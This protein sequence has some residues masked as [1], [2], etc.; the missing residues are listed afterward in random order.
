MTKRS[1]E[2]LS[3]VKQQ[4]IAALRSGEYK[5]GRWALR[6]D[7][8]YCCFG[9]LCDLYAKAHPKACWND[10][11]NT[12]LPDSST[13]KWSTAE[14]PPEE[15]FVWAGNKDGM[16]GWVVDIDPDKTLTFGVP[17]YPAKTLTNGEPQHLDTLNDSLLY[18]FDQIADIIE[19]QLIAV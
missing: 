5:Q 12:F 8:G 7:S 4:W 13:P 3:S 19:E 15:V 10:E 18:S 6:T 16:T 17:E 11:Q 9:V 14:M 1:N 2:I